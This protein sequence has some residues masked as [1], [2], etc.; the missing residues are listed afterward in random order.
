MHRWLNYTLSITLSINL[1][2][3]FCSCGGEKYSMKP[4]SISMGEDKAFFHNYGLVKKPLNFVLLIPPSDENQVLLIENPHINKIKLKFLN[5]GSEWSFG[6]HM[7]FDRRPIQFRQFAIPISALDTGDT[8]FLEVDKSQESLS[9]GL[10]LMSQNAFLE[11]QKQDDRLIGFLIGFTLFSVVIGLVLMPGILSKKAIFFLLYIFLSLLWLLNDA[12][13][14]FQYVWPEN[15]VFHSVSRG[16]FSTT[17]MFMFAFYVYLSNNERIN[18]AIKKIFIV[19]IVFIVFK[20]TF[21]F[22]LGLRIFPDYIKGYYISVNSITLTL[23][24]GL[25]IYLILKEFLKKADNFFELGSI[26]F[27]CFYVFSQSLSEI[28][29]TLVRLP[30][31][32]QF[33]ALIFI[34]LQIFF[35][36]VH[37]KREET[38]QK[39]QSLKE[40]SDFQISQERLLKNRIIEVEEFERRRIAQNIHDDVGSV[41]AATKY[42]ILSLQKKLRTKDIQNEF[43]SILELLDEGVKNQYSIIDDLISNFDQGESLE[44]AVRKKI[45][46]VFSEGGVELE[47]LF[48]VPE[49]ALSIH[50][51]TQLFRIFTELIT[52]T[53]K[54]GVGVTFVSLQ[55]KGPLPIQVFYSDDG[56]ATSSKVNSKGKGLENIKFRIDQLQG[57]IQELIINPGFRI[58]FQIPR[59]Q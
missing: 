27:Y 25:L 31:L 34:G 17:S 14:F 8:L 15:P 51:K 45:E 58:K 41:L 5:R 13:L 39:L 9:L 12:G 53:L 26:F 52:N 38:R 19:S 37:I 23:L 16:L 10:K 43:I 6:D 59:S 18:K 49:N 22:L 24:F 36:T 29:I 40:F 4:I 48:L 44:M 20:L 50:Q 54:H 7:N 35:M 3:F 56:K 28:G 1:V 2:F 46:L 21:N 42:Q 30:F 11:Y 55:I 57:T 32:H 47:V 33:E